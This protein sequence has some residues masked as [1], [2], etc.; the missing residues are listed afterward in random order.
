MNVGI[1]MMISSHSPSLP[2]VAHVMKRFPFLHKQPSKSY[3]HDS[4]VNIFSIR[5]IRFHQYNVI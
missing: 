5:E 1:E 2:D 3:I 4:G